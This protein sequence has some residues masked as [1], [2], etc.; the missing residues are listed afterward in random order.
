M[1]NLTRKNF[2]K[3]TVLIKENDLSRKLFILRTG[4]VVVY[5]KHMSGKINLAVLEA[6]EIFGEL[7]FFDAKKRSASVQALTDIAVDCIDG[8]T[9]EDEIKE[10]PSWVHIIF[11]SVAQ[12]FRK[13]DDKMTVLQSM[14]DFQSK[15]FSGDTIAIDVY[16]EL[17]RFIKIISM[18]ISKEGN[19]FDKNAIVNQLGEVSGKSIV[20]PKGLV[21]A[22][23]DHEFF[24]HDHYHLK[25]RYQF[26]E[27]ELKSF[28][29]FL[30]EKLNENNC[31]ILSNEAISVFKRII[32]S[33]DMMAIG[34]S[35][36]KVII[37]PEVLPT[38]DEPNLLR[39]YSELLK[40]DIFIHENDNLT[41]CPDRLIYD[42]RFY[43]VIKAFDQSSLYKE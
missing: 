23:F 28:Q 3:G 39:G 34:A 9:L 43:M 13:V 14:I 15:S 1:I 33:V 26:N 37:A 10:L 30:E 18:L 5:K 2:K 8:L 41:I 11:K 35:K 40:H 29:E 20:S 32:S 19:S 6:G 27:N 31:F 17:L 24:D 21:R 25:N 36:E 16:S 4:K 12:R 7:S 38:K 22:M 42:F